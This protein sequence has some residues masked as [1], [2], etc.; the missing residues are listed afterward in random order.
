MIYGLRTTYG[1]L[2]R[3]DVAGEFRSD[4]VLLDIGLPRLYGYEV[5]RRF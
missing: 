3:S 2:K 4:V 1:E 5:C